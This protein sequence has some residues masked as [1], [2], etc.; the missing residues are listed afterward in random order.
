MTVIDIL[1]GGADPEFGLAQPGLE[2]AVTPFGHLVIDEE[3]QAF[4][5]TQL[6]FMLSQTRDTK[7]AKA[8]FRKTL[9]AT[10]TVDPRVVTVDKNAAYPPA[11]KELKEEEAMPEGCKLR[12]S[13][14]LNNI[15]EQDHRGVKRRIN[16]GL[17]FGSFQTA[18]RTIRG[19]EVMHMYRKGQVNGADRGDVLAQNAAIAGLFGVG[20]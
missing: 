2:L 19:Y 17:G 16:A 14:Y 3:S 20:V 9:G 18:E 8:F 5:E 10:H 7:A 1:K 4:F 15:I 13:K 6:D 12:Q 11:V